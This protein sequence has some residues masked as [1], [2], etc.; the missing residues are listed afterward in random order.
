MTVAS[1]WK[2]LD[3]GGSGECVDIAE[4]REKRPILAVDLSIWIC[5]GL[6]AF[7][8]KDQHKNPALYL[9]FTRAIKL[10]LLGVKLVFVA[11]G[12]R[13]TENGTRKRRS[14]TPFLN[15]LKECQ[16]FLE[17]MGVPIVRAKWEGEALCALLSQRGL[18]D[19]VISNDGDCFPF[20]AKVVYTKYSNENLDQ[21]R[22]VKY[23]SDALSVLTHATEERCDGKET[24]TIKLRR[25]DLI[26]FAILTGSDVAGGGLPNVGH[27]KALRFITKCHNDHPLSLD[28]ASLDELTSWAR[29]LRGMQ[30]ESPQTAEKKVSCCSCCGH[31]GSKRNHLKHGC[32]RC[33][34]KPGEPCFA[35]TTEDRFRKSLR[36]KVLGLNEPFNPSH[37]IQVYMNPNDNQMPRQLINGIPAY[38]VP[39]LYDLLKSKHVVKGQ[40]VEGS[41]AFVRQSVMRVLS[42]FELE[43]WKT[44]ETNSSPIEKMHRTAPVPLK[45]IK[46]LTK[47]NSRCYEVVWI[48]KAT[49]TDEEGD[50]IDEYEY[51]T[52]EQKDLVMSK[53]PELVKAF[54]A[55]ER[56]RSAQGDEMQRQ[57]QLFLE[58][59]LHPKKRDG[60][61]VEPKKAKQRHTKSK[62]TR[63]VFFEDSKVHL[64]RKKNGLLRPTTLNWGGDV[65]HLLRF[66]T[67]ANFEHSEPKNNPD[68]TVHSPLCENKFPLSIH[69]TPVQDDRV[70]C[71]MGGVEVEI[72]PIE[73]N[74][75]AYPPSHIFVR[76][77]ITS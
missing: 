50:G 24:N 33:G 17:L 47:H 52:V 45:I 25:S 46:S 72:T 64:A 40:S 55:L 7:G 15:A 19:G 5:E 13:R 44:D 62:R 73:S 4:F 6:T 42:R 29:S 68:T 3:A 77:D 61:A 18:V 37:T 75:G 58:K 54:E 36:D 74:H 76:S 70:F 32:D 53:F 66:A 35:M 57:R 28:S 48:L 22:V 71:Q 1:L 59:F 27:R 69:M 20:G 41:R 2:A 16:E 67:G 31:E 65:G 8:M 63:A 9:V 34:T 26:S 56:K 38:F 43:T 11:E 14:G 39:R 60:E 30:C 49:I 12:G 10:L 23:K 51:V 21:G